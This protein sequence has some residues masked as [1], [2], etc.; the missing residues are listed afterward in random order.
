MHF[1]LDCRFAVGF[2]D[3]DIDRAA[4]ACAINAGGL[5]VSCLTRG[6]DARLPRRETMADL[7]VSRACSFIRHARKSILEVS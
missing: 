3:G 6:R 7:L 1:H 4:K 5:V 2:E